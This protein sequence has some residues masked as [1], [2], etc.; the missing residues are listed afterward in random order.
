[1]ERSGSSRDATR[2][3]IRRLCSDRSRPY[4]SFA[5]DLVEI[6]TLEREQR[7]EYVESSQVAPPWRFGKLMLEYAVKARRIDEI[8][9]A[10]TKGYCAAECDRLPVGCCSIQ[11][12]DMGLVPD[13]MLELQEIEAR[14]FGWIAPE[15][16]EKC[17]FHGDAGCVLR[18]FKS[19]ACVGMLCDPLVA[20]LAGRFDRSR[21]GPFLERL[22]VFRNCD[23]DRV[24]V[25]EAM[26]QVI[27]SG[28]RLLAG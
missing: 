3:L 8:L 7:S 24:R 4:E 2:E 5:L 17:K 11:G 22:A 12:Y 19:P 10:L 21:L 9:G 13:G 26:D 16:E 1:M 6:L 28:E 27:A 25:F 15:R 14:Q 18:L 23:I 20:D